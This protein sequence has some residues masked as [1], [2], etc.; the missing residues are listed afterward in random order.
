[1]AETVIIGD[2]EVGVE[3]F[4]NDWA[5]A[6]M[7]RGVIVRLTISRWRASTKLTADELGLK[8]VDDKSLVFM[9]DY[10]NLGKCKLLPPEIINE[11]DTLE[12][13]ARSCLI[14]HSFDTIW[15]KFVPNTAFE[16]WEVRNRETHD[17]FLKW[18]NELG[19]KY[20]DILSEVKKDYRNMAK[21]V[22]ARLYPSDPT[23][24]T[25]SFIEGF[26]AKIIAKIPSRVD[27]VSSFKYETTFFV[28]P[29]P[30]LVE[31]NLARAQDIKRESE[32]QDFQAELDKRVKQ[33]IADEYI[34][35]KRELVDGFLESTVTSMRK[36]VSELCDGVLQ[37]INKKASVDKV[38]INEV[39]KLKK[40]IKKIRYLN[41]YNDAEVN[42]LLK[43]LEVE[44]DK[45]AGDRSDGAIID[46][47]KQIT[48]ISSQEFQP[49]KSFATAVNYLEI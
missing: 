5:L 43:D 16:E 26:V 30:S 40:M 21:D 29:M 7:S 14:E 33:R 12:R 32:L 31:E 46:K 9:R 4:R 42:G 47:L 37:A 48:E 28:I 18:A 27:V 24:A 1:M 23:G 22:W 2:K 36:Y 45:N 15:G 10:I 11:M 6:L 13:R 25:E 34:N 49:E 8:F 38:T 44:V 20:D 41:F 19:L 35:R 39:N 17:D 3:Q